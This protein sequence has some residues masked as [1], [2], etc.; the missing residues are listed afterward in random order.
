MY[1]DKLD[2]MSFSVAFILVYCLL[3]LP[4]KVLTETLTKSIVGFGYK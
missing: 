2:G 1:G 3:N 4:M